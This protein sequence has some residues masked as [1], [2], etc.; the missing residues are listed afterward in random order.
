M[1]RI[2][3]GTCVQCIARDKFA[4]DGH[5]QVAN[6]KSSGGRCRTRLDLDNPHIASGAEKDDAKA[7][8][9]QAVVLPRPAMHDSDRRVRAL[10][11]KCVRPK[12]V[13]V[14]DVGIPVLQHA[15]SAAARVDEFLLRLPR[16]AILIVAGLLHDAKAEAQ[17]DN[18]KPRSPD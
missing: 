13:C 8:W 14:R 4:I 18:Y 6:G 5:E 10:D 15:R 7:T 1:T 2:K 16:L 11:E 12:S 17:D 3:L 9:L